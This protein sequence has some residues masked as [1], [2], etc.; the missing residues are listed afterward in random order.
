MLDGGNWAWEAR[1]LPGGR[2]TE[3]TTGL[4]GIWRAGVIRRLSNEDKQNLRG[5]QRY[6]PFE[7][8]RVLHHLPLV[9]T[10][11]LGARLVDVCLCVCVWCD[12]MM[13]SGM[14]ESDRQA[15]QPRAA[16][17]TRLLDHALLDN[18]S[19]SINV[20]CLACRHVGAS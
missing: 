2:V 15:V 17:Q 6:L 11:W 18:T 14:S 19:K 8:E 4:N 10:A 1:L 3:P 12:G 13:L 16:M 5:T 20:P 7:R 9:V